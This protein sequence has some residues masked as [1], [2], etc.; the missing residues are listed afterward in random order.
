MLQFF[1]FI[2]QSTISAQNYYHKDIAL[3]NF[4]PDFNLL[5]CNHLCLDLDCMLAKPQLSSEL[6]R[7][8]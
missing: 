7:H 3:N 4:T 8:K 6:S 5:A 1:Y 2:L